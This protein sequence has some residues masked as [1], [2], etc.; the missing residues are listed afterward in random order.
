VSGGARGVILQHAPARRH[1]VDL[2]EL[3]CEIPPIREDL[4][5]VET[6]GAEVW[7]LALNEKDVEES[8]I[9]EIRARFA[10]EHGVPVVFPFRDG[11]D[12]LAEEIL[13]RI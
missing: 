3:G 12:E 13:R 11:V 4:R 5:L 1:Y 6:L 7:G 9:P 2:V 8:T 10:A